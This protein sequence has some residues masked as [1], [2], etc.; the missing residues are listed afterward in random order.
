M[1]QN[2]NYSNGKIGDWHGMPVVVMKQ[3]AFDRY[4]AA[5]DTIYAVSTGDYNELMLVTG[6]AIIATMKPDGTVNEYNDP[7]SYEKR[8]EKPVR[9]K[10]AEVKPVDTAAVE[11]EFTKVEQVE[12][13]F[14]LSEKVDAYLAAMAA[15]TIYD[16]LL[17]DGAALTN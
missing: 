7:I 15:D 10:R 4:H 11:V 6:G 5:N 8:R 3:K 17:F 9:G 12:D 13:L 1:A 2:F 16:K 14:K